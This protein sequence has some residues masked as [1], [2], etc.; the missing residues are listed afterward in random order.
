[1]IREWEKLE[2]YDPERILSCLRDIALTLPL[3]TLPYSEASLRK[4]NLR[5]YGESRQCA[6]FCYGIS[7]AFNIKISYA[8][9]ER[10]D[11][12][13]V[14]VRVDDDNL[15]YTPIQMKELVPENVN[16]KVSLE[17][18]LEKLKKYSN[19]KDLVV[20]IHLNRA[21]KININELTIP[22]LNISELWFFGAADETQEKWHLI[23]NILRNPQYYEF[24]YPKN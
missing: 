2:Y 23:G 15:Y 4:R 19:S 7:K 5:Q 11:Y 21:G 22:E 9:Y 16:S 1:M 14:A 13:F 12:D 18:E 20:A 10:S 24:Q 3:D 8:H 17:Q 6:L